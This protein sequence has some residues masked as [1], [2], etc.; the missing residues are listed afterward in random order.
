MATVM[1][2]PMTQAILILWEPEMRMPTKVDFAQM[3]RASNIHREGQS[4][5]D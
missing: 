5:S 3:N 1:K 4:T 2:Q